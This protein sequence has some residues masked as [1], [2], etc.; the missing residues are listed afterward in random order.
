MA[1]RDFLGEKENNEKYLSDILASRGQ[2][3]NSELT[4][5]R[6]RIESGRDQALGGGLSDLLS[7]VSSTY[8]TPSG[9][10][11][12]S[13]IRRR[14][15]A[16]SNLNLAKTGRDLRV[17]SAGLGLDQANALAGNARNERL[18]SEDFATNSMNQHNSQLA[19]EEALRLKI[20][21]MRKQ[22][23]MGD[24][25]ADQGVSLQNQ[26]APQDDYQSALMRILVGLPVQLGTSYM[27]NKSLN[28]P[29]VMPYE[30]RLPSNQGSLRTNTAF[31]RNIDPM[32]GRAL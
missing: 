2:G 8:G 14:L 17:Q 10:A 31:S 22:A 15:G 28:Q 7:N 25:F 4:G 30:G 13:A 24:R 18:A 32:T 12:T 23:D 26:Y 5:T 29:K 20:E 6:G 19:Q 9:A 21:Q 3:I 1:I 16:A 11:D 27:L